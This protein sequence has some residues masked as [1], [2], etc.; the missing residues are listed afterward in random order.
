M[1]NVHAEL[2]DAIYARQDGRSERAACLN[3]IGALTS[4][5]FPHSAQSDR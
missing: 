1:M 5:H 3:D 2:C 4:N